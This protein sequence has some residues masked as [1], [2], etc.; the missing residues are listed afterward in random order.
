VPSVKSQA[1]PQVRRLWLFGLD[2]ELARGADPFA[3]PRLARRAAK[4]CQPKMRHKLAA[5][6]ERVIETTDE[7]PRPLTAAVPLNRCAIR[8]LRPL[9]LTIADDLRADDP[10]SANGVAIVRELLRDGGSPLYAGGR[11]GEL[12][13]ELRRARAALLLA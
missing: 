6:I 3:S 10:V 5:D 4:L 12:E 13:E 2:R 1:P 9:L 11:P 7:P 8:D